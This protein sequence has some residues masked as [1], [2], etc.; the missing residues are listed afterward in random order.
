MALVSKSIEEIIEQLDSGYK[1]DL[2]A[3]RVIT[4]GTPSN[5]NYYDDEWWYYE[6]NY[7]YNNEISGLAKLNAAQ[8]SVAARSLSLWSDVA[9]INFKFSASSKTKPDITFQNVKD[10]FDEYGY[11]W[12]YYP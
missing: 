3:D 7:Y 6:G 1:W 4:W 10:P 2:G 5:A 9:D 8:T 11:A 12:A